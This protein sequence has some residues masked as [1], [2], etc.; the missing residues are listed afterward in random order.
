MNYTTTPVLTTP[1]AVGTTTREI[2]ND[3]L[4]DNNRTND[5]DNTATKYTKPKDKDEWMIS[6][7]ETSI[8][9]TIFVWFR[10]IHFTFVPLMIFLIHKV[11]MM[12]SIYI[13]YYT[14]SIRGVFSN[15]KILQIIS[16]HRTAFIFFYDQGYAKED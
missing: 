16:K 7:V 12:N 14:V 8:I 9:D 4:T 6:E 5:D 11:C 1:M 3:T 10:Y 15:I 2:S 13:P